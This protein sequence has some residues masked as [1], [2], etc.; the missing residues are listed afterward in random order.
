MIK[1]RKERKLCYDINRFKKETSYSKITH[2]HKIHENK[3]YVFSPEKGILIDERGNV[4]LYSKGI[5]L[6]DYREERITPLIDTGEILDQVPEVKTK[7][8]FSTLMNKLKK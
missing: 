3:L 4:Y 7:G 6:S 5:L 8:A 2:I 1:K